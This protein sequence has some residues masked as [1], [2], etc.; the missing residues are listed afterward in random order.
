MPTAVEFSTWIAVGPCFHQISVRVVRIGTSVWVLTKMVAYS[1]S[2]ADG[3]LLRMIL[4]TTSKMPLTVGTKSSR[5]LGLVGPLLR[6]WTP[7]ARLLAWDT[8]SYDASECMANCIP[9]SLYWISAC[10]LEAR[11]VRSLATCFA[12]VFVALDWSEEMSLRAV[13]IV[14][15]IAMA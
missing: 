10:G 2:T 4:H 14:S 5:L 1:A 13:R 9:L 8:E 6:K 11:Y 3:M 12:V 7:L 15:S